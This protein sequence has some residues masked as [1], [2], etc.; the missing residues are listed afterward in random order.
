MYSACSWI[1]LSV[2]SV[3]AVYS[4][5]RYLYSAVSAT[6]YMSSMS[7]SVSAALEP[8]GRMLA[9]SSVLSDIVAS[10]QEERSNAAKKS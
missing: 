6:A 1:S 9:K 7:S 10:L 3:Q 5:A 2:S 4:S 8:R